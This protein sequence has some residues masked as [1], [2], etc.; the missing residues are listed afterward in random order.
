MDKIIPFA[1]PIV[2]ESM[3]KAVQCVLESG[4]F[5][6]GDNVKKFEKEFA[7]YC[8]VRYGVG[9]GSGTS[10]LHLALIA[11]GI[12]GGDEVMTAPNTF[13]ATAFAISYI[14]ARPIFVDVDETYT[15]NPDLI[16]Q[17]IT[18]RT[19]AIIP[20]HLYG[21][22]CQMDVINEIAEKHGL[23]VIED[24]CQAHGAEFKDKKCGRLGDMACFSF[25]PS[26]NMTVCGDGGVIVTNDKVFYEKLKF[27]RN[28]GQGGRNVHSL[29]GYNSRLSE[30]SAAIAREQLKYLDTWNEA[31]RNHA[32]LYTKLLEKVVKT[33]VEKLGNHVYHLYV[34]RHRKRD[35]LKKHLRE[36]GIISRIHYPTP[37]YDQPCYRLNFSCPAAEEYSKEILSLPIYPELMETE[38]KEISNSI[39]NFVR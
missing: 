24:A 25:Y 14:G 12:K 9:V 32:K 8:G 20:V 4:S 18:D 29:I 19:K 11:A 33:P 13:V 27:L 35:K 31:R 34:I 23:R 28:Y 17:K 36:N 16:E 30:I 10:A 38:I 15:I 3:K 1:K 21:H 5:V 26:K 39:I 37:I 7:E 2:T 6:L 22:P